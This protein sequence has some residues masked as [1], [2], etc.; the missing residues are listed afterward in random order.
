M[1]RSYGY[2]PGCGKQLGGSNSKSS[3]ISNI[4]TT[5][6]ESAASTTTNSFLGLPQQYPSSSTT[7]TV[8]AA[9][10][11][12]KRPL[13]FEQFNVKKSEERQGLSFRATKKS[14]SKSK[15]N[16]HS[17]PSGGVN[18]VTINIGIMVVKLDGK[19]EPLRGKGLPLKIKKDAKSD[20]ILQAAIK[21]RIDF[22]RSFRS[23]YLYRLLYPDGQE[24]VDLPGSNE[25][26]SLLKYKE[27][28][29]KTFA[30]LTM[31]LGYNEINET[32]SSDDDAS[33][34]PFDL[35]NDIDD[36]LATADSSNPALSNILTTNA[37]AANNDVNGLLASNI[38]AGIIASQGI[39]NRDELILPISGSHDR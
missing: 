12:L 3:P 9:S 25:P 5:A 1:R 11:P 28:L 37:N 27:A 10:N 26:F 39:E 31:Y 23:D 17:H 32:Y 21:K 33:S 35:D 30:R 2:C 34:A 19:V 18:D 6:Q 20:E 13:T 14:K 4:T 38:T 22:D 7:P 15:A 29:G 16:K 8:V 24:V 36:L